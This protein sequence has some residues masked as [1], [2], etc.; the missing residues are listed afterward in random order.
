MNRR[1]LIGVTMD[2]HDKPEKYALN[3]DYTAAIEKAGGLPWPIPFMTEQSLI[4]EIVDRLD[5]VLFTGGDD[6]HPRRYSGEDWHSKAIKIDERREAFEF[7]LMAEVERRR[8]PALGICFGS[9]LMNV[10][11]GG[12]LHQ[13]L[14]EV[15]TEIEHRRLDRQVPRHDVSV[16]VNSQL[17]RAMGRERVSVNTFHKQGVKTIGRGL[18]VIATAP[19]GLIEGFEDPSLPL[20]AAVQWHPERLHGEDEHLGLFKVLV[21]K[22]RCAS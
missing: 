7:A 6:M 2:S 11:R 16:D 4:P 17:G 13:F 10:F 14:P 20:F 5:G 8:R 12:S 1:P 22:A 3:A 18:K 19:D 15:G 9:Q 21:E